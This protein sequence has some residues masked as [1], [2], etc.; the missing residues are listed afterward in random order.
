M[1]S[2][3]ESRII[4]FNEHRLAS[5][6]RIIFVV[7]FFFLFDIV[8]LDVRSVAKECSKLLSFFCLVEYQLETVILDRVFWKYQLFGESDE[9]SDWRRREQCVYHESV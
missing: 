1:F 2:A 5:F 3:S 6:F 8:N 4:W 7:L 9:V